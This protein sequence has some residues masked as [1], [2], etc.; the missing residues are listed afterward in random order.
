MSHPKFSIRIDQQGKV[1]IREIKNQEGL[2]LILLESQKPTLAEWKKSHYQQL[3]ENYMS[4]KSKQGSLNSEYINE[5]ISKD[6]E[7]KKA[8]AGKGLLNRLTN[9]VKRKTKQVKK[10]TEKTKPRRNKYSHLI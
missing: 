7:I 2:K 8:M 9:M 10:I 4:K 5:L 1:L 6:P 3:I